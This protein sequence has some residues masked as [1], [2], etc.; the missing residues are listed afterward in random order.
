MNRRFW[1]ELKG[2]NHLFLL[3]ATLSSTFVADRSQKIKKRMKVSL[4]NMHAS[5]S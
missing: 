2:L 3:A 4:I 5:K 1:N